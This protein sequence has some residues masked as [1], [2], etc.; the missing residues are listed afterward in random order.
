MGARKFILSKRAERAYKLWQKYDGL[1]K[2]CRPGSKREQ[3][4]L[5]LSTQ[6]FDEWNKLFTEYSAL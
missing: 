6:H 4:Y 2:Y 5:K 1:L 3:R